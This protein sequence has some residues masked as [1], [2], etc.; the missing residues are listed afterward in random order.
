MMTLTRLPSGPRGAFGKHFMAA[1]RAEHGSEAAVIAALTPQAK[2]LFSLAVVRFKAS[3]ASSASSYITVP[4]TPKIKG[5]VETERMGWVCRSARLLCA[6]WRALMASA[7][8]APFRSIA[9]AI[10]SGLSRRRTEGLKR[11]DR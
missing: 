2:A 3:N 11:L 5:A 7:Y 4:H 1:V 6:F 10:E 9:A 8:C